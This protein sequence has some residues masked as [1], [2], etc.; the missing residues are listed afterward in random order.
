MNQVL[1]LTPGYHCHHQCLTRRLDGFLL[2]R[3]LVDL[4]LGA[5]CFG[6]FILRFPLPEWIITL[7]KVEKIIREY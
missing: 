1:P 4:G 5:S 3:L 2:G 7:L 6:R